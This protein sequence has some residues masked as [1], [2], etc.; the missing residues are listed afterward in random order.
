M[1]TAESRT[2]AVKVEPM[3]DRSV[4]LSLHEKARMQRIEN[5]ITF[6]MVNPLIVLFGVST[7]R[8]TVVALA[9]PNRQQLAALSF[10]QGRH[11]YHT[12]K[13]PLHCIVR[14]QANII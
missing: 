6:F 12:L 14:C 13:R 4:D 11:S 1:L 10:Y 2:A 9:P 5:A 7:N 3:S 8:G